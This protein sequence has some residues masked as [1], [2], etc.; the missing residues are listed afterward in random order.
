MDRPQRNPSND[1]DVVAINHEILY[2]TPEQIGIGAKPM[3]AARRKQLLALVDSIANLF[4]AYEVKG[5]EKC[6]VGR[7]CQSALEFNN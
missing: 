7:L 4:D 5:S 1:G 6:Y 2:N 3:S